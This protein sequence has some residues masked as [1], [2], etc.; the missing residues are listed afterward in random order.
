MTSRSVPLLRSSNQLGATL[1]L[2]LALVLLS[3]HEFVEASLFCLT[4]LRLAVRLVRI[5]HFRLHCAC[6]TSTLRRARSAS[7]HRARLPNINHFKLKTNFIFCS[8]VFILEG[9][10][11]DIVAENAFVIFHLELF[12]I[13]RITVVVV[14]RV[15]A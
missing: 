2:L 14:R 8:L 1:T 7:K 10:D 12:F 4:S 6:L 9:A 15:L 5:E 3:N 13:V 11:V